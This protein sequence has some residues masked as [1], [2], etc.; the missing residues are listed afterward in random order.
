MVPLTNVY[1]KNDGEPGYKDKYIRIKVNF[2]STFFLDKKVSKNEC[3][4]WKSILLP[5]SIA[6]VD[7][8]INH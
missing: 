8:K 6:N 2:Y 1:K 4:T 5:D 7:K 3:Y